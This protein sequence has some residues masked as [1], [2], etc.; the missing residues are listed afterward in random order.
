MYWLGKAASLK[1][2]HD[3]KKHYGEK[4]DVIPSFPLL[5]YL[6]RYTKRGEGR[7]GGAEGEDNYPTTLPMMCF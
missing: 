7:G 5:Y 3:W 4:L 6:L 1:Q 2:M